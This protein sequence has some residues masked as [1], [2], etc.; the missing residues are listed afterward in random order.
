MK[1]DQFQ[2]IFGE[3]LFPLIGILFWDWTLDF[4]CWFYCIDQLVKLC[5]LPFS[6]PKENKSVKSSGLGISLWLLCEVVLIICIIFLTSPD[7]S[8][9]FKAFF[10]LKD[11]GM[12]QG[13]FLI[14]LVVLG[15]FMKL[16]MDQKQK[17][18]SQKRIEERIK[19]K[20]LTLIKI[21]LWGLFITILRFDWVQNPFL[22][23]FLIG[24]L[25]L[26]H[27]LFELRNRFFSRK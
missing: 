9:S 8:M 23:Y 18:G 22:S 19:L 11:I 27:L 26:S 24:F 4:V 2:R 1:G 10:F 14:P 13:Y 20:Q 15:E 21:C 12:S 5:F 7:L 3:V 17:L 25:A 6:S 16:K